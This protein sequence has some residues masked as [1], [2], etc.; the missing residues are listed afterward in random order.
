MALDEKVV[1]RNLL[2]ELRAIRVRVDRQIASVQR[3]LSTAVRKKLSKKKSQG[4][5]PETKQKANI[6]SSVGK[7]V[8]ARSVGYVSDRKALSRRLVRK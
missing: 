6:S 2:T 5:K 3:A 1:L 4:R 8:S 7:R